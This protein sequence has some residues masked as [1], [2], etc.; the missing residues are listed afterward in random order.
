MNANSRPDDAVNSSQLRPFFCVL[1]YIVAA[2]FVLV[3][4]TGFML[5]AIQRDS[6]LPAVSFLNWGFSI[7][8]WQMARTGCVSR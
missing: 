4:T 6:S 2:V 8:D 1:V 3:G 7:T 5:A